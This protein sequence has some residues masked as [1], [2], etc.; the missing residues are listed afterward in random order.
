MRMNRAYRVFERL[1][2]PIT[3]EELVDRIGEMEFEVQNGIET[4]ED[5]FARV[6]PETYANS[7]EAHLMFLSALSTK[8]IGRKAYS[9]RDPPMF[10]IGDI[11]PRA[12]A[13][14]LEDETRFDVD[15][16]HCGICQHMKRVGD[17]DVMAYCPLR[18]DIVEPQVDKVCSDYVSMG[19]GYEEEASRS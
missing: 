14:L 1:P 6:Q 18:R 3:T 19:W 9:D 16:P 4:V 5:V 15:G 17:W 7:D 2:Y 8:A 13:P 10:G 12:V 11:D